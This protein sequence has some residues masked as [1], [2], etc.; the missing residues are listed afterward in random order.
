VRYVI[1][2][3]CVLFARPAF[4]DEVTLHVDAATAALLM[5]LEGTDAAPHW[6]EACVAPCT[7]TVRRDT[8]LMIAEKPYVHRSRAFY[9]K[10]TAGSDIMLTVNGGRPSAATAGAVAGFVG[11][12]LSAVGLVALFVGFVE[13]TPICFFPSFAAVTAGDGAE[14]FGGVLLVTGFVT[15]AMNRTTTVTQAP[16]PGGLPFT[17][18]LARREG[19]PRLPSNAGLTIVRLAF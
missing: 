3:A 17:Q 1:P 6:S 13:N 16:W 15:Y 19:G 7:V 5:K 9:P 8:R 4:A 12:L 14:A 11:A 2:L 18:D 10:A